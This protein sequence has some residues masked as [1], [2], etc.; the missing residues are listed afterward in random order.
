MADIGQERACFFLKADPSH[1]TVHALDTSLGE[2]GSAALVSGP[3]PPGQVSVCACPLCDLP[4][5]RVSPTER[6]GGGRGEL[7]AHADGRAPEPDCILHPRRAAIPLDSTALQGP[8]AANRDCRAEL[9]LPR[10]GGSGGCFNAA[11]ESTLHS[12]D[13]ADH[14]GATAKCRGSGL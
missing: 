14:A 10:A 9:C 7:K 1:G 4:L 11:A 8:P 12:N 3:K 13:C 5:E 2:W 6:G